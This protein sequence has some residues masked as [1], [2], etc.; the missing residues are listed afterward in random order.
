MSTMTLKNKVGRKLGTL[1]LAG[2]L[3]TGGVAVAQVAAAPEA[4]AAVCGSV[5]ARPG[6]AYASNGCGYAQASVGRI[7]SGKGKSVTATKYR[8]WVSVSYKAGSHWYSQG[9]VW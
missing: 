7:V 3:A 5:S 4:E 9:K 2:A 8:G 1:L 6:Y